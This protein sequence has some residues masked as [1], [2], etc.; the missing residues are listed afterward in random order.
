MVAPRAA[1]ITLKCGRRCTNV[2]GGVRGGV[3]VGQRGQPD[4]PQQRHGKT[5]GGGPEG[6]R[7][8]SIGA[9]EQLMKPQRGAPQKHTRRK[10]G[11]GGDRM[12][13][14]RGCCWRGLA[15]G[16]DGRA[17]ARDGQAGAAHATRGIHQP[18][19]ATATAT[20]APLLPPSTTVPM[21]L[22]TLGWGARPSPSHP[23]CRPW[24]R[25][26]RWQPPAEHPPVDGDACR[27]QHRTHGVVAVTGNGAV[28]GSGAPPSSPPPHKTGRWRPPW[29][30]GR[31]RAATSLHRC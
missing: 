27:H 7:E 31:A 11:A 23:P 2:I 25:L 19:V 13:A 6:G 16:A 28:G 12:T 9:R 5:P 15:V 21:S 24:Q 30:R 4:G 1:L 17:G 18:A 22:L 10:G 8:S 14:A 20:P 26:H 3:G 29:Q